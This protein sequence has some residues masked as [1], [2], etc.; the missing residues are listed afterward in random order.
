MQTLVEQDLA[1]IWH[2]CSQMKDYETFPPLVIQQAKGSYLYLDDGR[3]L[4][5][6]VSS[7]WCKSLGHNHPRL[8]TALLNQL[9]QFEHV[10]LANTCQAPLVELSN[11]LTTLFAHQGLNKIFYAGDGSCAI[12]VALKMSL[13]A[14][15][16]SG[17]F[18]KKQFIALENGYHGE[19]FAALSISDVG[20]YRAPFADYLFTPT[21]IESI[22]Y[23]SGENDP[24]FKDCEA[25]WQTFILPQLERIDTT[26]VTALVFEPLIQGA[27]GMK[28]YSADFLH[29][30]ASWAKARDIHL[31]ADE[32]LTGLG[33]AGSLL[34]CEQAHITPDFVCLS[35]GLTSGWLA[36]SAVLT[37]DPIYDLFFDDYASG[38]AFLHSHTFCGNA[39]GAS[40]ALAVLDVLTEEK[41]CAR[42]NV[43]GAQMQAQMTAIA[44]KTG[45]LHNIRQLGA[46]VAA[47]LI[48]PGGSQYQ[49]MGYQ[50]YQA[51]CKRGA[52][53]RP[54]GN[55]IYWLP[56]LNMSEET[57]LELR[58]ITEQA[59]ADCF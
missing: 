39:M 5:D 40:L 11:R 6:A 33:R 55:T 8:K 38:K 58:T 4:I 14:R 24:L 28:I 22:P 31:I 13:Q 7:W 50:V 44:N 3:K 53:L 16:Q 9:E 57:L 59:I 54:L 25:H 26:Y 48:I 19:T 32:I 47:D 36:F 42:A 41:L 10:I 21:F 43:L 2:P 29:R 17:N 20:L 35:K 49:R 15:R 27:G 56:P 46:V 30:L 12:E 23:V 37:T 45:R 18:K 1:H 52:L 51:A 34:A